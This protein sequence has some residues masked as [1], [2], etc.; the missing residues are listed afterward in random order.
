MVMK[1]RLG[2]SL[3]AGLMG[4]IA[5]LGVADKAAAHAVSIGYENAGA[6]GAVTIWLGTYSSGHAAL[7]N[8]GSMQLEGALGTIFGPE[9]KFFN[10]LA[11]VGVG[12]KPAGLIDGTTN[13]YAPNGSTT[14][15]NND[16]LV[17]TEASFNLL[18]GACGPVDRWQGVTFFGLTPGDYQFTWIPIANPTLQWDILNNNMNGIFRISGEVTGGTTVPEPGTYTMMFL[19]LA[20]VGFVKHRSRK[21][22]AS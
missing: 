20:L 10:L 19:G 17:D 22:T 8:E 1:S 15:G 5:L 2:R 21:T 18:C 14:V 16:P 4:A 3:T 7:I 9:T 11:G 12:L 6:P 13:F